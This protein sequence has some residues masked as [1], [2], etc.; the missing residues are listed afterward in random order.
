MTQ[1]HVFPE[2]IG[3]GA[4]QGDP[5]DA[6]NF[7]AYAQHELLSNYKANGLNV[8][9]DFNANTFDLSAGK[10]FIRDS[11]ADTAQV[12]ETRDRGVLYGVEVAPRT[13][14][15]LTDSAV[16]HIFIELDLGTDD[17]V[18]V[19]ARTNVQNTAPPSIK[20][21]EV[22]TT[23]DTLDEDYS[24]TFDTSGIDIQ[25]PK[26]RLG[27]VSIHSKT[28]GSGIELVL[29]SDEGVV[30]SNDYTVDGELTIKD[31]GSLTVV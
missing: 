5:A 31:G 30:V 9:V 7:G 16:N 29:G 10:A 23:A 13:G 22:D 4:P 2:D 14:L 1:D 28:L 18:S 15:S 6:A 26:I 27:E 17:G 25:A 8:T 24:A 12:V 21:A 11:S 3:T 20:I 19:Q